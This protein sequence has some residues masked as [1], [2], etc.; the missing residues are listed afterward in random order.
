MI[1]GSIHSLAVIRA[2]STHLTTVSQGIGAKTVEV[3]R[4]RSRTHS[5]LLFIPTTRFGEELL[6]IPTTRFGEELLGRAL[7]AVWGPRYQRCCAVTLRINQDN[8]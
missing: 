2:T 8:G 6:G 1:V 5:G 4:T 3:L 7:L